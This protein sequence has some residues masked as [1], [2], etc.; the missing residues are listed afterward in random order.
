MQSWHQ[1]TCP[2][3]DMV[4]TG[5]QTHTHQTRRRRLE[6]RLEKLKCTGWCNVMLYVM[7]LMTCWGLAISFRRKVQEELGALKG[8]EVREAVLVGGG[9]EREM[10]QED[11]FCRAVACP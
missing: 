11:S 7:L 10:G 2:C 8:L 1:T 4:P 5:W 9:G 3:G 6:K